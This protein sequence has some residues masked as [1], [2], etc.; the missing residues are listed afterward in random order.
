MRQFQSAEYTDE[1]D[2][3]VA[4]NSN[5]I[6]LLR[7]ILNT[8]KCRYE[9]DF[10]KVITNKYARGGLDN[11]ECLHLCTAILEHRFKTNKELEGYEYYVH[12]LPIAQGYLNFRLADMQPFLDD[13]TEGWYKTKF[14]KTEIEELKQNPRFKGI[15]FDNCL[16]EVPK[17]DD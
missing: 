17:E 9:T 16:E 1:N 5:E 8:P 6:E 15:D 7:E 11:Y 3:Y 2:K 10:L 13:T 4:L 12:V 14:T